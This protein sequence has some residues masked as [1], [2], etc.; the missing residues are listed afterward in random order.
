MAV[1]LQGEFSP[2]GDKSISHRALLFSALAAGRSEIAGLNPG[3]DVEATRALLGALGTTIA[4]EGG[5]VVLEG[6]GGRFR[7][8]SGP[9]DCGNSGTTM[10]LATGLLA[11]RDVTATL[12]GDASLSGRPMER[13]AEPLRQM[14]ARV[15][16]TDGHAPIR[17]EPA[18]M[19]TPIT[20]RSPV[21]SAQIKSAVLL[22]ALDV[23][24]T[25][26]VREPGRSRDHTERMLG[27]MGAAITVDADAI[28]LTGG[29]ALDPIRM[30]VPGDASSAAFFLSAAAALPGSRVTAIGVGL[31]P[32]RTGFLGVLERMGAPVGIAGL[33]VEGGEPAG[34][35]TVEGA[36]LH[37][38]TVEADEVPSLIDEIPIL[39]VIAAVADG[40]TEIRGAAELRVKESDRLKAVAMGLSALGAGVEERPDGLSIS[41]G[42][43]RRG[44]SVASESDHRIAMSF[45]VADLL[46]PERVHVDDA[47]VSDVSDP[48]FAG[49]LAGLVVR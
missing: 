8:P 2:P 22:A 13:V 47:G 28:R 30:T 25:T 27:A 44:G 4:D 33:R 20:F 49:V 35:V 18:G 14:G 7:S 29:A 15:V 6:A 34:D 42:G 45:A 48:A 23:A 3:R 1:R 17:I 5:R 12:I 40:P 39:A 16:T 38:T 37:G 46:C 26:V 31:N 24:G 9:L 41:G 19:L 32:T 21:A 36:R 11:A 10:R 43:Y